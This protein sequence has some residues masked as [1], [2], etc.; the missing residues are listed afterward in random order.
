MSIEGRCRSAVCL[1]GYFKDV[2]ALH[3]SAKR[4]LG[5][6]GI[7]WYP[8]SSFLL[9]FFNQVAGKN[10]PEN[11]YPLISYLWEYARQTDDLFDRSTKFPSSDET[12]TA[13]AS[14]RGKLITAIQKAEITDLQKNELTD[15]IRELR[16]RVYQAFEDQ[17]NWIKQPSFEKAFNYRK[18]SSLLLMRKIAVMGNIL[19]LTSDER[20]KRVEDC[21]EDI[22]VIMQFIDDLM[23][24]EEDSLLDGNLIH[25]VLH[26][27]DEQE[28]FTRALSL[29]PDQTGLFKLLEDSAPKTKLFISRII[30]QSLANLESNSFSVGI[31]V[32]F[33]TGLLLKNVK[34]SRQ[35]RDFLS[36]F[37]NEMHRL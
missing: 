10:I 17:N 27:E 8:V 2:A 23:D 26:D 28:L 13:T 14:A 7:I 31:S 4:R 32:K 21:L 11:T 37:A 22:G 33:F 5:K 18:N 1:A 3:Y 9:P 36:K 34:I 15:E 24:V 30:A 6:D 25:A 20:K 12:D 19:A 35:K 16:E 29:A